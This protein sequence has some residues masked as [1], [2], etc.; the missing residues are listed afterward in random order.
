MSFIN[1]IFVYNI[2]HLMSIILECL[3]AGI[4]SAIC[5]IISYKIIYKTHNKT[6]S[7]KVFGNLQNANNNLSIEQPEIRNNIIMCFVIGSFIHYIIKS[8]N[9]TDMY[10]KK[11]CYDDKCF[12]VCKI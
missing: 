9:I 12:L 4:M 1:I 7:T 2:I 3:I 5:C 11:V 10:C 6:S 8:N